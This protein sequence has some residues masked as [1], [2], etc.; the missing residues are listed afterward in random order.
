ML[1]KNLEFPQNAKNASRGTCDVAYKQE[2]VCFI[3]K[4]IS[5][6]SL[7]IARLQRTVL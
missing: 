3:E 6:I 2:N 5:L 7:A 4:K 1:R